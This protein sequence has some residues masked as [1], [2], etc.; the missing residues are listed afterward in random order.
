MKLPFREGLE[1][2]VKGFE[3][4]AEDRLW[5]QYCHLYPSMCRKELVFMSFKDFK[6]RHM[7]GIP[8][9][10]KREKGPPTDELIE[11]AAKVKERDLR[12]MKGG[13]SKNETI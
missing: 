7:L 4:A 11:W 9:H 3:K 13:A 5:E 10:T 1:L 6:E 2:I 12:R 8:K